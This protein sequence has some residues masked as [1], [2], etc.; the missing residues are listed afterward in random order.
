[1]KDKFK[2]FILKK[3]F[4]YGDS[5]ISLSDGTESL[6][7]TDLTTP[8]IKKERNRLSKIRHKFKVDAEVAA[9]NKFAATKS[10]QGL[11]KVFNWSTNRFELLNV[12]SVK[13]VTPLNKILNNKG[14]DE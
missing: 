14:R 2:H 10:L 6:V 11:I 7:T 13:R 5:L 8:Y 9:Y 12:Y 1:M 3:L 4:S